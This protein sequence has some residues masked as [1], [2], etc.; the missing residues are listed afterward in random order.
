MTAP[1]PLFPV[2][3]FR[4]GG[5][6]IRASEVVAGLARRLWPSKTA[7]HLAS[8]CD[9]SVRAAGLW[10]EGSNNISADALIELLRSDAG[11]HFLSE[12]MNGADL[13]W[14]RAVQNAQRLDEISRK[15]ALLTAELDA[16][17]ALV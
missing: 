7:Q 14:W 4:I 10:L 17:K 1:L 11:F 8:R 13:R 5:I 2:A 15:H 3:R 9:V 16:V 12:I 6:K